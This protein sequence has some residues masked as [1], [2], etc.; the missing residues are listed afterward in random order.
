MEKNKSKTKQ[1]DTTKKSIIL[2][3][4]VM[5]KST[6]DGAV[7][8]GEEISLTYTWYRVMELQ[9]KQWVE[10]DQDK[11]PSRDHILGTFSQKV[12]NQTPWREEELMDMS[13]E[14]KVGKA[15]YGTLTT[16]NFEGK[17]NYRQMEEKLRLH[18]ESHISRGLKQTYQSA[19]KMART[20][21]HMMEGF[22]AL[23]AEG[24][25]RGALHLTTTTEFWVAAVSK[26]GALYE[27]HG[28]FVYSKDDKVKVT[29]MNAQK[30]VIS[31]G[32]AFPGT[33]Q[34]SKQGLFEEGNEGLAN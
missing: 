5:G 3:H 34:F 23:T 25:T 11:M 21:P 20:D 7:K 16:W 2:K 32:E 9:D 30:C 18:K 8:F 14:G 10:F 29:P 4:Q 28:S 22:I 31:Y 13:E 27:D 26:F 19:V 12:Q 33:A 15:V 17:K 1:G 6:T 24:T